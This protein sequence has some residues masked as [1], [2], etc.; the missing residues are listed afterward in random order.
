MYYGNEEQKQAA[1]QHEIDS[2]REA[3]AA[4][5]HLRKVLESFDG[6]VFN[7]RL[8]KALREDGNL[9]IVELKHGGY[10]GDLLQI[11]FCHRRGEMPLYDWHYLLSANLGSATDKNPKWDGKRLPAALLI[12]AAAEQR[13]YLLKEAAAIEEA[14]ERVPQLTQQMEYL[15]AQFRALADSIPYTVARICNLNYR[16][17]Q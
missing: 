5:P 15:K 3:A 8:E 11:R 17:T 13:A 10:C 6:K 4:F 7:C 16:I 1:L 14:R 12:D 9:W 2:R